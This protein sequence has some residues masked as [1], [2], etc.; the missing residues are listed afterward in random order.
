MSAMGASG[1]ILCYGRRNSVHTPT[2]RQIFNAGEL[3]GQTLFLPPFNQLLPCCTIMSLSCLQ[4]G[5]QRVEAEKLLE[6]IE[7]EIQE[8]RVPPLEAPREQQLGESFPTNAPLPHPKRSVVVSCQSQ[9]VILGP[10]FNEAY[11][12]RRHSQA[13]TDSPLPPYTPFQARSDKRLN[14]S[15]P[16]N[17]AGWQRL[18]SREES[19]DLTNPPP[20]EDYGHRVGTA[21]GQQSQQP[22]SFWKARYIDHGDFVTIRG[23]RGL[24]D[25]YANPANKPRLYESHRFLTT[26]SLDIQN[27]DPGSWK[28]IPVRTPASLTGS[29]PAATT[30]AAPTTQPPATSASASQSDAVNSSQGLTAAHPTQG[31]GLTKS[32]HYPI[33]KVP[34][35]SHHSSPGLVKASI[36]NPTASESTAVEATTAKSPSA[37]SIASGSTVGKSSAAVST[38]SDSTLVES[39]SRAQ[40]FVTAPESPDLTYFVGADTSTELGS[41]SEDGHYPEEAYLES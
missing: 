39:S 24:Q 1:V 8:H 5:E 10:T 2:N 36:E 29:A 25:W 20:L 3:L 15:A 35:T 23:P 7:K 41:V 34:K 18:S 28:S 22:Q 11:Q 26:L 33:S 21:A 4:E 16:Q 14:R 9:T 13:W 31:S 40:S 19:C 12:R 30:P 38:T 6:Q 17:F 27:R 32:S 37:E